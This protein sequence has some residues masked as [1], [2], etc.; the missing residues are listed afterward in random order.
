MSD[1]GSGIINVR[2][3]K[4]LIKDLDDIA[5]DEKTD[6]ASI[7]R[8]ILAE[9]VQKRKMK[10]AIELYRKGLISL[11]KA[12]EIAGVSLWD[13]IEFKSELKV[14]YINSEEDIIAEIIEIL[15][16]SNIDITDRLLKEKL[17]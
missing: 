12:A 17:K 3:D 15:K 14:P 16:R 8:Q 1:T 6:R 11:E 4:Q 7:I 9:V 2:V 5:K 10:K 13:M